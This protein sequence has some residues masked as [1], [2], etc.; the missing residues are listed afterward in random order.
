MSAD[1]TI[2]QFLSLNV[3][4]AALSAYVDTLAQHEARAALGLL[5]EEIAVRRRELAQLEH[6]KAALQADLEQLGYARM[7]RLIVYLPIF[8]RH[9]WTVVRPDEVAALCGRLVP[10]L[11]PS[12]YF[13]PSIETVRAMRDRFQGLDAAEREQILSFCH[14]LRHRLE[15]RAEMRGLL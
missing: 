3:D 15:V 7:D 2:Q 5:E 6:D 13:E 9:F 4:T 14:S 10:P 11:V 12:P 1:D 8:F